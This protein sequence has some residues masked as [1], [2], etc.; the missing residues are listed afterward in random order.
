MAADLASAGDTVPHGS[1]NLYDNVYA[2]FASSAEAAVRQETYGEDLGQSSW[3]TAR[4][5][6]GFADQ[7]GIGAG[8]EVLE[9]GSGSGGPA[10]YLALA[11]GCHITGVDINEH[12]V[13]NAI[14][15]ADSRGIAARAHFQSVDASRPLPFPEDRFDAIVSN[16]AMCHIG[17][18][19]ATLR[20]WYR[21][22]RPGGRALF[23]DAMVLTGIVSHEELATRSSI[24]FY[25]LVP[26][27]ENVKLLRQAGF[28]IRNTEDVT[29]NAAEVAERWH[30]ARD[31][32]QEALVA[33]EGQA[34]FAGLQRFL[35]CVHTLSVEHRLSRFAYLA[36]KPT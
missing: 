19:L 32:H 2:D 8:S 7:L 30:D 36:E 33:R 28:V 13:R 15:L 3:L 34:T 23:T 22:L 27:G 1:I 31:R 11:R 21:V 5:W 6:L 18:R 4:E 35:R 17:G 14:G 25:L 24:G 12:G 9:V 10:V 29:A 16:D 20:D 26:P